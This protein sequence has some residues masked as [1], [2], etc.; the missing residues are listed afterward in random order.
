MDLK[1]NQE[2]IENA[3]FPMFVS[4]K[5]LS[6]E[7]EHL[8]GFT[9]E[10]AWVTHAGDTKLDIKLAIRPTSETIIYPYFS[11]WIRTYKDLPMKI[12]QWCNVVRWEFKDPT[13]FIRSR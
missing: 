12:N 7:Q 6:K 1:F 8:E 5:T 13:P 11:K 2:E 3:Y 4:E 10:V 9:P